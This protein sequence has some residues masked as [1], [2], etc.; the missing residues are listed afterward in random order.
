MSLKEKRKSWEKKWGKR[1]W[2]I[3]YIPII[4]KTIL[5]LRGSTWWNKY[6]WNVLKLL[7]YENIDQDLGIF[8][9]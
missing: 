8:F 7:F 9:I 6:H 5:V 3:C 1:K 4:R 2:L